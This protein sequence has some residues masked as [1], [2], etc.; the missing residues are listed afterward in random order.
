MKKHLLLVVALFASTFAFSQTILLNEDFESYDEGDLIAESSADFTTW[1]GTNAEDAPVSTDLAASGSK[2]L[3]FEASTVQ[4]GPTDIVIPLGLESGN[5]GLQFAI[6]VPEGFGAYYN[7]QTTTTPGDGW[8]WDIIF[9]ADGTVVLEIEGDEQASGSFNHG[10][11]IVMSHL[12]NLDDNS[13]QF[14]MDDTPFGSITYDGNAGGIN[15][16]AYA[17]GVDQGLYYVDNVSLVDLTTTVQEQASP[18]FSIFPNPTSD[19]VNLDVSGIAPGSLITVFD[20]TGKSVFEESTNGKT[21]KIAV[22]DWQNGMYFIQIE[23]NFGVTIRR[24]VVN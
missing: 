10:E 9:N 2:S 21:Q 19:V 17:N 12:I 18:E 20:L 7:M 5:Y 4:G 1:S 14:I 11:W 3:K 24:L 15:L 23:N 6:Y 22:D 13:I 8:A 16:F